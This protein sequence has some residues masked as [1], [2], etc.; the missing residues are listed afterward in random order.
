VD[1]AGGGDGEGERGEGRGLSA[2]SVPA[3][4]HRQQAGR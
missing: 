3:E 1:P 4:E 2:G